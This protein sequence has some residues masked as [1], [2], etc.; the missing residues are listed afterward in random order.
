MKERES[1]EKPNVISIGFKLGVGLFIVL[2]IVVLGSIKLISILTAAI[3][4]QQKSATANV[5]ETK[6]GQPPAAASTSADAASSTLHS[7]PRNPANDAAYIERVRASQELMSALGYK[8]IAHAI[9][10]S[11]F[12]SVLTISDAI[13]L[14]RRP[15]GDSARGEVLMLREDLATGRQSQ[16]TEYMPEDDR[17]RLRA[18]LDAAIEKQ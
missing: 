1:S 10:Q 18:M 3:D 11:G 14:L 15:I 16:L 6:A 2:P 7:L 12:D 17:A 4:A 8:N 13:A 9:D 5:A